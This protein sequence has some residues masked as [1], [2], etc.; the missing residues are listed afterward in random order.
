[1]FAEVI[2]WHHRCGTFKARTQELLTGTRFSGKLRERKKK[3]LRNATRVDHEN[4]DGLFGAR[5]LKNHSVQILNSSREFR[6]AAQCFVN[7]FQLFVESAGPFEVQ[8]FAGFFTFGFV[9]RTQRSTAR[10][11][12]LHEFLHLDVIFLFAAAA[13]TRGQ[14][15]FHFRINAAGERRVATDFDLAAADFEKIEN[16]LGKRFGGFA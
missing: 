3:W 14:A 6:L 9:R 4:R 16:A 5:A 13:K 1:M 8:F 10:F 15:H 12:K 11:Q 7:F 2:R